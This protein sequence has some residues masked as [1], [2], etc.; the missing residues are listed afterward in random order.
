MPCIGCTAA[1]PK[2]SLNQV[3]PGVSFEAVIRNP[4]EYK[5]KVILAGG[6]I[7]GTTV[8]VIAQLADLRRGRTA[9]G[10][11]S[12]L[13]LMVFYIPSTREASAHAASSAT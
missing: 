4:D 5:G 13:P 2:E 6:Q 7:L 1:I 3:D 10:K 8:Q 11:V 9:N 12:G